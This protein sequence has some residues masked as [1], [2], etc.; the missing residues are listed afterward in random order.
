MSFARIRW[1]ED[2]IQRLSTNNAAM[3]VGAFLLDFTE[4]LGFVQEN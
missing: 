4:S 3:K 2:L 1:A